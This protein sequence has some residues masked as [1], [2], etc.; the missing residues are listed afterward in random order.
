MNTA[1]ISGNL[2][3]DPDLRFTANGKAVASFS[4]AAASNYVKSNGEGKEITDWLNVVC[5][6]KLAESV[7]NT[8]TKGDNVLV[9]GRISTRSYEAK[10]GT[11]RYVTEI[12]ADY[13]SRNIT[14]DGKI[15]K[16]DSSFDSYGSDVNEEEIPF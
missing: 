12:I 1:I 13:V 11:K 3:R 7:G 6:G 10:D 14:N 8:L 4:V 5:W 16:N 9:K 2:G 15:Q